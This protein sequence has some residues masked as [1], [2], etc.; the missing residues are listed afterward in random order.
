MIKVGDLVMPQGIPRRREGMF[1]PKPKQPGI[2]VKVN[3]KVFVVGVV[4]PDE[5]EMRW[6]PRASL[7]KVSQDG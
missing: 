7:Q 1:A 2:V 3:N 6:V 4:W 5:P